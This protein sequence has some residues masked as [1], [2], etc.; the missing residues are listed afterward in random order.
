MALRATIVAILLCSRTAQA[1]MYP[2]VY[3]VQRPG[4][5]GKPVRSNAR[6]APSTGWAATAAAQAGMVLRRLLANPGTIDR[7]F[8]N[9]FYPAESGLTWSM[10]TGGS[11]KQIDPSNAQ[12]RVAGPAAARWRLGH[13]IGRVELPLMGSRG[14]GSW[15]S[16]SALGIAAN[17][18]LN[19]F[20]IGPA[21]FDLDLMG[22]RSSR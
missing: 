21:V 9:L 5:A 7:F 19:P 20:L 15:S 22:G 8:S 6:A 14:A 1:D 16:D 18:S 13:T 3:P 12:W 2:V 17:G 10:L 11:V 4:R